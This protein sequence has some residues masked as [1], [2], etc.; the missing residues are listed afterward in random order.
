MRY[1]DGHC[2]CQNFSPDSSRSLEALLAEADRK[3][4]RHICLT[5][6]YDKDGVDGQLIPGVSPMGGAPAPG[7]W[8]FPID[9]YFRTL[10]ALQEERRLDPESCQLHIGIEI[11]Y[12]PHL[13]SAYRDF[14]PNWDLD[15]IIYS[16]H[17][18]QGADLYMHREVYDLGKRE[19]YERWLEWQIAMLESQPG[20][21]VLGHYDYMTRY[22]PYADRQLRYR[23]FPD[24]MDRLLRLLIDQDIALEIN[25]KNYYSQ[26]QPEEEARGARLED[27]FDSELIRRYKDLGGRLL[28]LHSDAHNEGCLC[29]AFKTYLRALRQAGWEQLCYFRRRRPQLV[30]ID[31]L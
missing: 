11:N 10:L 26:V 4:L 18:F 14:L 3:G 29:R 30:P 7:E 23:D 27:F 8:I 9:D 1:F 20:V 13:V 22:A 21:D 19:F 15:Q 2:H 31:E 5:D 28:C 17:F 25:T 12:A 24:H 16:A 6:H